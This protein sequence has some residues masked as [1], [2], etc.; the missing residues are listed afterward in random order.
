MSFVK[1]QTGIAV[2][3]T[4]TPALATVPSGHSLNDVGT[5]DNDSPPNAETGPGESFNQGVKVIVRPSRADAVSM[6][7]LG[8]GG[9]NTVGF[10]VAVTV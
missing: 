10:N 6:L 5:K 1:V 2:G 8:N 4:I 3:T 9:G 7:A